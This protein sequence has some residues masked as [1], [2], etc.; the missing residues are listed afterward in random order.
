MRTVI[1]KFKARVDKLEEAKRILYALVVP[2]LQQEGCIQFDL[3][4]S[5]DEPG[6]FFLYENWADDESLEKHLK[7]D[8]NEDFQRKSKGLLQ[9]PMEIFF[10][11]RI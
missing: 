7:N 8:Y 3:H 5:N 11:S 6:T 9:A 2:T 1:T 10:V 4:Q